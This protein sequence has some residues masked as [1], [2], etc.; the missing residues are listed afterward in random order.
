M[1]LEPIQTPEGRAPVSPQIAVRVAVLGTIALVMFGIIFFRLWYL[2]VLTGNRYVQQA[3]AQH[4]RR[5]PIPAPRGKILA[6]NGQELVSSKT[7]NAVQIVASELPESI[8]GQMAAY[9]EAVKAA[10]QREKPIQEQITAV[11]ADLDSIQAGIASLAGSTAYAAHHQHLTAKQRA[12]KREVEARKHELERRAQ[13]FT[14]EL[15]LLQRKLNAAAKIA[16]PPLPARN[17][18]LRAL[19]SRL[20]SV[21]GKSPREIDE[22]VIKGVYATRYAPVTIDAS[23]GRGALTVLGERR[24][25]F[26]GVEQRPVAI[27]S[28]PYGE[29]AAQVFG[30][31][32]ALNAEE[33]KQPAYKG[34]VPGEVVGQNGLEAQYDKYLRGKPGVERVDVNALGEPLP[35]DLPSTPPTS[36]YSLQTTLDLGLQQAG[37]KA[38]RGEIRIAN[39]AGRPA[40]GGAF[41]VMN[42][43]NGEIYA[44]GSYPSY[45]PSIFTKPISEAKYRELVPQH[46]PTSGGAPLTNR[47]V[48]SGY[49]VGSTFKPIISIGALESGFLDPYELM[50]AGE[51]LHVSGQTFCNA[52]NEN[53]AATD[54]VHALEES[55]DTYFYTVGMK[56]FHHGGTPLQQWAE[57]LGIGRTTGIDLPNELTGLVPDEK[58]VQHED[59]EEEE[60]MRK[61]HGERCYIVY[62]PNEL[63]TIGQSMQ[64][65]VGQG[66]L[67]TSPLQMA[68]AYSALIDAYRSGGEATVVT[69]HLGMQID[70]ANGNLVQSLARDFPIRRRFHLNPTWLNLIFEGIH[71]AATGPK[72][73]STNVWQG[74]NNAS[75]PVYGKTGTAERY[76]QEVQA[77][78]MCYIG[79]EKHPIVIASTVEQGGYGD[80]AAAPIARALAERFYHQPEAK[81]VAGLPIP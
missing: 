52:E 24:R 23:A 10:G 53:F 25:E 11:Q 80:E 70:E 55:S 77:W 51:C 62:S 65:A 56:A 67:V 32:G 58:W 45:N 30:Y 36:G 31:V 64:L 14:H 39:E 49:V 78:Y 8:G 44:M 74:W 48:A 18:R 79:S 66:S 60:C 68:V 40:D 69:P 1:S 50:G 5:L 21:L 42:P 26:P 29:M 63:W 59:K 76:G 38:L 72:G 37:E 41:V 16:V 15:K 7:T 73:T 61:H 47:A 57:R 19:F 33:L 3:S 20:G 28:Y 71:D 54:L 46:T 34:A 75:Y 12:A 2:Q 6:R 35:S 17:V 9:E 43:L 81:L 13:H 22:R 4:M 27:R